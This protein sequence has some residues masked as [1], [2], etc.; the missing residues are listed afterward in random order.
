MWRKWHQRSRMHTIAATTAAAT[1]R[2]AGTIA[3]CQAFRR[4]AQLLGAGAI[5]ILDTRWRQERARSK[6]HHG[7]FLN[8]RKRLQRMAA[9]TTSVEDGSLIHHT[10]PRCMHEAASTRP[11]GMQVC[12]LGVHPLDRV[13]AVGVG[14]EVRSNSGLA[15]DG[16]QLLNGPVP[17]AKPVTVHI[18]LP[19]VSI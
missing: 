14:S 4:H 15:L 7:S 17:K 18:Q 6:S 8:S 13:D 11:F 12:E 5:N 16:H 10:L 3:N 19:A 1:E 2:T 9:A